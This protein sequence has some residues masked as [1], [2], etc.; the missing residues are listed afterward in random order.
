VDIG[1]LEVCFVL[2][3]QRNGL[4]M[5]LCQWAR[6]ELITGRKWSTKPQTS[7]LRCLKPSLLPN[8]CLVVRI[9]CWSAQVFLNYQL[10]WYWLLRSCL[11]WKKNMFF[12]FFLLSS[13]SL[14]NSGKQRGQMY[15]NLE[16]VKASVRNA[17]CF[18]KTKMSGWDKT[19][20]IVCIVYLIKLR[21][22]S[23]TV[24]FYFWYQLYCN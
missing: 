2:T 23:I 14:S 18:L 20:K 5:T 10:Q 7:F 13:R 1:I 4:K 16:S 12:M 15:S 21:H 3:G 22:F 19:R 17:M 6:A 9:G 8:V 11:T 24:I